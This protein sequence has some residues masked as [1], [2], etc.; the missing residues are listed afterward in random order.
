MAATTR[1]GPT[2]E[3]IHWLTPPRCYRPHLIHIIIRVTNRIR[4]LAL[5]DLNLNP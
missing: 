4:G 2:V 1:P 3:K 5:R